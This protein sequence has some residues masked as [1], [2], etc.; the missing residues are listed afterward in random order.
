[1]GDERHSRR[2]GL[3]A[4]AGDVV[5]PYDARLSWRGLHLKVTTWHC[6]CDLDRHAGQPGGTVFRVRRR[7]LAALLS[8]RKKTSI[9]L[10]R[11]RTAFMVRQRYLWRVDLTGHDA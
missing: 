5:N 10:N 6:A 11:P 2:Q 3:R 8:D 7:R 9:R 4:M 1:M